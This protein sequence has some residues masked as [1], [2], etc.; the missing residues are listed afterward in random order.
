MQGYL[1]RASGAGDPFATARMNRRQSCWCVFSNV[2][3]KG[4]RDC[5]LV[6]GAVFHQAFESVDTPE[7]DLDLV[8]AELFNGLAVAVSDLAFSTEPVSAGRVG[9]AYAR[10]D[11]GQYGDQT[12]S[13]VGDRLVPVRRL[14]N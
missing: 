3:S 9:D 5:G 7:L 12:S 6:G 1:G 4:F 14:N 11:R 2:R 10:T 13:G 8:V